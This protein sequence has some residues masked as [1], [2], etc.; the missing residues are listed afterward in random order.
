MQIYIKNLTGR[1]YPLNV[2][3]ENT[4]E[5]VKQQV[6]EKEG[7]EV[8]QMRLIYNGKQ[9]DDAKTLGEYNIPAGATIHL[10]LQLRG[11]SR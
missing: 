10:I 9:L 6:Q 2:E 11:G 4:L 1:K 5:A 8:A 7:I 3:S